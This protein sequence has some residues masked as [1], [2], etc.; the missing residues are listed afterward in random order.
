[1]QGQ[2]GREALP[3][4]RPLAAERLGD[5]AVIAI[6]EVPHKDPADIQAL[7]LGEARRKKLLNEFLIPARSEM[8][9]T[10][11]DKAFRKVEVLVVCDMLLDGF[12]GADS[13]SLVSGT[14]S[15]R[16]TRCCKPSPA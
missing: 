11:R 9:S 13:A 2:G 14:I 8:D 16:T 12:D 7:Y 10:P 6:S 4:T 1:M 5:E 15:C 3:T